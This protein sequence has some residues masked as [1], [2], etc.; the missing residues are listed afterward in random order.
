MEPNPPACTCSICF[1]MIESSATMRLSR[2]TVPTPTVIVVLTRSR[3]SLGLNAPNWPDTLTTISL[4]WCVIN[5]LWISLK[6]VLNPTSATMR[7]ISSIF[8]RAESY[9]RAATPVFT[10]AKLFLS[11]PATSLPTP[12]R[13]LRTSSR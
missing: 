1:A 6:T 3:H 13:C 10:L 4:S 7:A 12:V 11:K 5:N 2:D 8:M 9:A